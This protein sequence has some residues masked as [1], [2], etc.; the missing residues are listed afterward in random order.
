MSGSSDTG[1]IEPEAR[2]SLSTSK[3]LAFAAITLLA[4]LGAIELLIRVSGVAEH[5]NVPYGA[6]NRVCDPILNFRNSPELKIHGRPLNSDGFRTHEFSR[7]SPGV[8]RVVSLGDSCTIGVFAEELVGYVKEPYPAR[9]ERIARQRIG[10]DRVEVFN[11]GVSGYGSFHGLMLLR[12]K[13]RA[14]K[15]DLVTVRFGWNDHFI[16]LGVRGEHAFGETR[17]RFVLAIQDLLLR[18]KLYAFI[19]RMQL[20][21]L[22]NRGSEAKPAVP[23]EWVPAVPLDQYKHNL[24]RIA[25]VARAQGA[26]VWFITAAHA[27][28]TD[29][30]RGQYE[31]YADS[32]KGRM[33]L[34]L[35]RLSSYERFVEI[36]E[37]YTA[38]T[39]AVGEELGVT[40]IDMVPSYLERSAEHLFSRSDAMHPLQAGHNLEAEVLYESLVSAGL[41]DQ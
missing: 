3:R 22:A 15:P 10:P 27:F 13:V 28:L 26:D 35:N 20:E 30:Y 9:L 19:R 25:E 11:L 2:A 4:I 16:S 24:R 1:A 37:Q 29:E 8:F 23:A 34:N 36:H 31:R 18:T 33:T 39:R 5:C 6:W 32:V 17:N 21:L 40:V 38:A 41:V 7:K 12:T 14:L